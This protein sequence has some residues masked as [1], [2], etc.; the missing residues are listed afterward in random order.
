MYLS[1]APA[2]VASGPTGP[3]SGPT[4]LS[5][6][7]RDKPL[8]LVALVGPAAAIISLTALGLA[9]TFRELRRD[10]RQRRV[11]YRPRGPVKVDA[12]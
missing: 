3:G 9:L 11:V 1:S 6:D 5:R 7:E 10:L 4:T 2:P 12:R 8:S